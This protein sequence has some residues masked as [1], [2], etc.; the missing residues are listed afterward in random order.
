MLN[1]EDMLEL[2]RRMTVSRNNINRIAGAYMDSD[3]YIDGDF[4]VNFLNLD[5][6]DK[7]KNLA[8]AKAIP[9]AETNEQLKEYR[10]P[11]DGKEA[12]QMQMLLEGLRECGLKNDALMEN[13]YEYVGESYETTSD[14][15]IIMFHGTYDIPIKGSDKAEQWES[16]EVYDYIICAIC[17]LKDEYEPGLPECGFLYPSFKDRSSDVEHIAVFAVDS[18]FE[19]SIR[20][21][22]GV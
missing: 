22:V 13:F 11:G 15:S 14:Y 3:G 8:I 12:K 16:E 9:F 2:T 6:K 1:R 17:P 5:N 18:S 4:N 21:I 10:F 19:R 7:E 20:R